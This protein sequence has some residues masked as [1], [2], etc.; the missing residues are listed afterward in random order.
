MAAICISFNMGNCRNVGWNIPSNE[1]IK[2]ECEFQA[3]FA[4]KKHKE[5]GILKW[6]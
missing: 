3:N 5:V 2:I 1:K 4:G 6:N